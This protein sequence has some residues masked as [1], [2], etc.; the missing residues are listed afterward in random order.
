MKVSFQF[1]ATTAY[2]QS[3]A[4]QT[5]PPANAAT[6]FTAQLTGLPA[7]TTIHYRAVA[8]SDFGTFVGA[9]QTLTTSPTPSPRVGTVTVGQAEVTG[10]TAAVRVACAGAAGAQCAVSLNM[11]VTETFRGHK[12]IAV[13]ANVRHRVI[14]VGSAAVTLTAGNSATV[15]ISLNGAGRKLLA[16]RHGLKV[17]LVVT[18]ALGNGQSATVSTQTVTFKT[19]RHRH[20]RH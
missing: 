1:G 20:G 11:S 18:E 6:P 5:L 4:A 2:G 15:R 14:G 7:G 8:V 10:N 12:L 17:N 19:H 9:D 16:A 13:A 3:T